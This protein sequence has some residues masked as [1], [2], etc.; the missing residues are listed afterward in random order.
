VDFK[1]EDIRR[2]EAFEM[3]IWRRVMKL[4]WTENRTNEE[5]LQ[6]VETEREIMDTLRSRQ[7]RWIGHILRRDSL[8]KTTLKGRIQGN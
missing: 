8:L 5:V 1:K 3:W 4:S 6:T 2:L 7:K